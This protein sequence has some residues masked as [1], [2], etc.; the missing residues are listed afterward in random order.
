MKFK[1]VYQAIQQMEQRHDWTKQKVFLNRFHDYM[2]YK[3]NPQK[4]LKCI[5]ISGTNGKGSTCKALQLMMS[6]CGY[7]VGTFN[8]PNIVSR[9]DGIRIDGNAI[10]EEVYLNY[11]NQYYEEWEEFDLSIFEIEVFMSFL[12]F[13][14]QKVDYVIYEVGMG[15]KEDA[16]NVIDS[17]LSCITNIGM[18]HCSFLGNTYKEI[19]QTKA[20]IIKEHSLFITAEK[21]KECLDVFQD[22]CQKRHT[23]Q[24]FMK[25]PTSIKIT[26]SLYFD[27]EYLKNVCVPTL[28]YYQAM[29]ISLAISIIYALKQE[30]F[31]QYTDVQL[32]EALKKFAWPGRFEVMYTN[33][34][35]ILDGAHN[36]EGIDLL[37][38]SC[39]NISDLSIIFSALKDKP[40]ESMLES[41]SKVSNDI[42]VCEFDFYRA[43]NTDELSKN[44]NVQVIKD[45]KEAIQK[46]MKEKK[47]LL[48][49]G[50][51]YFIAMVRKYLK[52]EKYGI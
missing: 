9:M 36:K 4:A 24:I 15:G 26:N 21:R 37:V 8:S 34:L 48:I 13:L 46:K 50:S 30:G 29:N 3:K 33:P 5:H 39:K 28:A 16:T 35:V 14:E 19:A 2:E 40:Y 1:D 43:Q 27:T 6:E 10:K 17:I 51:L 32:L 31:I 44:H 52:G 49:C 25:D 23:K 41:L 20:G 11:V 18:D 45:Y 47:P 42:T 7:K 22:I 38:E 12:Y